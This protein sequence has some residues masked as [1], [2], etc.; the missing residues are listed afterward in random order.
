MHLGRYVGS[1][2]H[3]KYGVIDIDN[4]ETVTL[5]IHLMSID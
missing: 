1:G 2:L 3:G 4:A 5:I